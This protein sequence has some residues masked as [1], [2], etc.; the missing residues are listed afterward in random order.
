MTQQGDL[1]EPP[2]S[3]LQFA[4]DLAELRELKDRG[5]AEFQ[6][7]VGLFVRHFDFI[8]EKLIDDPRFFERD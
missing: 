5:N 3:L 1:Y 8:F 4:R 2:E 6:A 7:T